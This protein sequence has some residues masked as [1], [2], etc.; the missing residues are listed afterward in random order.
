MS[1]DAY[2]GHCTGAPS[3]TVPTSPTMELLV[4][5][6]AI[7]EDRRAWIA[8]GRDDAERPLTREGRRRM[9]RA[10][11]GLRR[12]VPEL[13]LLA[14]SPLMRARE[15]AM[16]VNA[17]YDGTP[18]GE[19]TPVLLPGAPLT[20]FLPWLATRREHG[21]VGVVGHDLHLSS[22]VSWLL[23]G[24]ARPLLELRKGAA[25]LLSFEHRIGSG[26]AC[27]RWLLQPS[28]LR[29]LGG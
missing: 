25:C 27:L 26:A 2:A 28:Q 8:E 10:A 29:R 22:L 21:L 14:C 13:P 19:E 5:R 17:A 7:A 16:I 3:P 4:I 20:D 24:R 6:H 9:R 12:I 23:T 15:T 11:R 18:A 1:G